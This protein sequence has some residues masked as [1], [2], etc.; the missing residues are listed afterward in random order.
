MAA[1]GSGSA[2]GGGEEMLSQGERGRESEKEC[3]ER[4]RGARGK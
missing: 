2:G 1:P 3:R 4:V